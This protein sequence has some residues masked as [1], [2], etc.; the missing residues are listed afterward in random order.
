MSTAKESCNTYREVQNDRRE[1][2]QGCN[3]SRQLE[4]GFWHTDSDSSGAWRKKMQKHAKA[5][6]I[7]LT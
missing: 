2:Q 5:F 4:Q 1:G 7:A 6:K 3:G